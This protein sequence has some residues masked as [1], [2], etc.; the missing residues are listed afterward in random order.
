M[1][2]FMNKSIALWCFM[3]VPVKHFNLKRILVVFFFQLSDWPK[4][5]SEGLASNR[6]HAW[7]MVHR[8]LRKCQ[9]CQ[10]R[11]LS[12]KTVVAQ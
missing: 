3:S 2:L 10:E 9:A 6:L 5:V 8:E 1:K 12:A 4:Y 11:K 7:C